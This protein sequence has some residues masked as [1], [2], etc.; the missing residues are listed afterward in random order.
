MFDQTFIVEAVISLKGVR[1]HVG[2]P[3]QALRVE[4]CYYDAVLVNRE[5]GEFGFCIGAKGGEP[6]GG[7]VYFAY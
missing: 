2:L 6:W 1:E 7:I 3:D 4:L 5:R